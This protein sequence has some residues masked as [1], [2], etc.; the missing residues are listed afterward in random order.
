MLKAWQMGAWHEPQRIDAV[1]AGD[2][3]V[4]A[5]NGAVSRG[6]DSISG[7]DD[8]RVVS[9]PVTRGLRPS[10]RCLEA[11]SSFRRRAEFRRPAI[12]AGASRRERLA[13][14]DSLIN[15]SCDIL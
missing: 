3:A 1:T 13:P 15:N 12:E 10:P 7:D 11:V 2:G 14:Q 4:A 5:G 8:R 6:I 9:A